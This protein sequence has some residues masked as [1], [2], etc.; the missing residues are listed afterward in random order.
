MNLPHPFNDM[1]YRG[2]IFTAEYSIGAQALQIY[3]GRRKFAGGEMLPIIERAK[4]VWE[5][6]P[7]CNM[8]EPTIVCRDNDDG[9]E[10]MQHLFN[11]LWDLGFRPP[12]SD[13]SGEVI[14]AKDQNLADLRTILFKKLG[15]EDA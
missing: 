2:L 11:S 8:P 14:A 13:P 5:E 15:I 7:P 6:I 1:S 9:H 3:I 12:K 4:L 10:Q